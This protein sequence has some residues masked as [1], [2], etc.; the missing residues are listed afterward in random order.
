MQSRLPTTHKDTVPKSAPNRQAYAPPMPASGEKPADS[1][2]EQGMEDA[3]LQR[4]QS[5]APRTTGLGRFLT[6][7][8][9]T[10]ES[11]APEV[12]PSHNAIRAC[13]Q[14]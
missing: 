11:V 14:A 7:I 4:A 10:G 5:R 2:P 9:M 1:P 8:G 6:R 3:Q 13:T 12:R